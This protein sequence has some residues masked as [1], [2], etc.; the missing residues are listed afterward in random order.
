VR[1]CAHVAAV[2]PP[3]DPADMI[4]KYFQ[5]CSSAVPAAIAG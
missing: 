2:M 5:Q 3:L 4:L 1:A